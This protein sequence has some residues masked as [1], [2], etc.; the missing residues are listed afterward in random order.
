[1]LKTPIVND[2]N[3]NNNNSN[4]TNTS[5]YYHHTR[6]EPR[7]QPPALVADA[8]LRVEVAEA[9]EELLLCPTYDDIIQ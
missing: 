6:P 8:V 3:D 4:N 5:M 7:G 9:A 2:S 1:M